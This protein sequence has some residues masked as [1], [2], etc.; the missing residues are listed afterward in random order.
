MRTDPDELEQILAFRKHDWQHPTSQD[1]VKVSKV[2]QICIHVNEIS[3]DNV[4]IGSLLG[5]KTRLS[6]KCACLNAAFWGKSLGNAGI[7]VSRSRT[8]L[9]DP[10]PVFS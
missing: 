1:S 9:L 10:A 3:V 6:S 4:N 8:A 7:G 2:S 5:S